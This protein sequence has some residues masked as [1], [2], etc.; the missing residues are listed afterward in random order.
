[1]SLK[2]LSIKDI[3]QGNAPRLQ[4]IY[5]ILASSSELSSLALS[6]LSGIVDAEGF[7]AEPVLLP[8]L[9]KV[10]ICDVGEQTTIALARLLRA[11]N[12]HELTVL[13]QS[14][15]TTNI[16]DFRALLRPTNS[17]SLLPLIIR[18]QRWKAIYVK[19]CHTSL[20]IS[21]TGGT[22]GVTPAPL[23][24][25]IQGAPGIQL[26]L[27][28]GSRDRGYNIDLDITESRLKSEDLDRALR[29][30][31]PSVLRVGPDRT[32][33]TM[34]AL[35]ATPPPSQEWFCPNLEENRK[36]SEGKEWI[37]SLS[38]ASKAVGVQCVWKGF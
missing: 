9:R 26:L 17:G 33:P 38:R 22:R 5:K 29:L 3:R 36:D 13:V 20:D 4:D 35:S 18:N 8:C 34:A 14:R 1:M 24:L 7:H 15:S 23:S 37:S 6:D 30:I 32:A 25:R 19:V 2:T 12:L 11:E 21:D 10:E 27:L 16:S 28:F 31:D